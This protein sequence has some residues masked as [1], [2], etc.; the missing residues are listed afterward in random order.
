MWFY[1]LIED[2]L[3]VM[4]HGVMDAR[5][6]VDVDFTTGVQRVQSESVIGVVLHHERF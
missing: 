4:P 5:H 2:I 3:V 1:K 6:G